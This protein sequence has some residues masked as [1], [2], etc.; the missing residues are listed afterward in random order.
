MKLTVL[1]CYGPY[2]HID[3]ACS[4]YLLQTEHTSILLDLGNGSLRNCLRHTDI[5]NIDA[6]FLSHLHPDH[7]SDVFVL[8]YMLEMKGLTKTLYA[9]NEPQDVFERLIYKNVFEINIS[10]KKSIQIKDMNIT[11]CRMHHAIPS[12]AVK[13]Q[14][15]EKTFVYSGDTGYNEKLEDFAYNSDLLLCEAAVSDTDTNRKEFHMSATQGCEL[16]LKAQCKK[17]IITHFF[18]EYENQM[19]LDEIEKYRPR[20]AVEPAKENNIYTV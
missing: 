7:I 8:R 13:V 17:L 1:G 4:G 12:Y 20:L 5:K 18:P 10:E 9:P 19:Y 2:P 16:A 15:E 6:V 3:G 11:L 14:S